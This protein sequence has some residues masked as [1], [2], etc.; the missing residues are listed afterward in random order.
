[1]KHLQT[2][3]L[4]L[5]FPLAVFASAWDETKY[6]QIEKSIRVPEFADRTFDIRKYGAALDA[7]PAQNHGGPFG[8]SWQFSR[9]YHKNHP[10]KV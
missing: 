6:K 9:P 4:C 3:L 10:E 7:T 1:M 5:L 8:G 2:L